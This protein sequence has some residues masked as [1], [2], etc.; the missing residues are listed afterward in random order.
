MIDYEFIGSNVEGAYTN[1]L[2]YCTCIWL[3]GWYVGGGELAFGLNIDTKKKK[4]ISLNWILDEYS[5][6]KPLAS[7][8]QS[9][10][11]MHDDLAYDEDPHLHC[12]NQH[13]IVEY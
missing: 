13:V 12:L 7:L 2:S 8:D 3:C 1:T 10:G 6:S 11:P 5:K 4:K 9:I